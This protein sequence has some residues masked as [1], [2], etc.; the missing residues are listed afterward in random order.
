MPAPPLV[1]AQMTSTLG[2]SVEAALCGQVRR[3]MTQPYMQPS[4]DAAAM[5]GWVVG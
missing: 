5:R 4:D 3:V 2:M 1:I